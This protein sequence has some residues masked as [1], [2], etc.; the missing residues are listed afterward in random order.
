MR[1]KVAPAAQG[2]PKAPAVTLGG[3]PADS[4]HDSLDATL[5]ALRWFA[6]GGQ[7]VAFAVAQWGLRLELPWPP[8]VIGACALGLSNALIGLWRQHREASEARLLTGLVV[9]LAALTW[10]LF[11]SGGVMNP[12]IQLYLVPVALTAT[13]LPASR[14]L[15]VAGAAALGYGLLAQVAP[16]LA[17]QHGAVLFDLQRT[18]MAANFALGLVLFCVFGLLLAR[19]LAARDEALRDARERRLRDEGLHALALQSASAAHD[20]N[21]PLNTAALLVD[22]WR[23]D[24]QHSPTPADL[25]LMAQQLAF[26]RDAVRRLAA[27]TR[28]APPSQTLAAMLDTLRDRLLLLRPQASLAVAVAP[29]IA[30]RTVQPSLALWGSLGHL[31]ENAADAGIAAGDPQ[32]ALRAEPGPDGGL[33]IVVRDRGAG[34]DS[35]AERPAVAPSTGGLGIGLAIANAT[36]EHLGGAL[37]VLPAT[38]GGSESRLDLPW[39]ALDPVPGAQR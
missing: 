33:R 31:L 17:H 20:I 15:A 26:A 19:R 25:A 34:F 6:V 18:G 16:P 21:T 8:L 11:F 37:H 28:E 38:G 32:L 24:P 7:F 3:M 2:A 29:A 13:A 35:R 27:T 23:A 9:D 22:E 12:F 10:A 5:Y 39:R 30:D 4:R 14:V 1:H 36:I